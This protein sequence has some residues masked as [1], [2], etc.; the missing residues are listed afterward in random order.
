MESEVSFLER[1][2]AMNLVMLQVVG[3][4]RNHSTVHGEPPSRPLGGT[5]WDHEPTIVQVA[6]NQRNHSAVHGEPPSTLCMPW[7]HE[8]GDCRWPMVDCRN[9]NV[10]RSAS[11]EEAIRASASPR[12]GASALTLR[13][14]APALRTSPVHGERPSRPLGGTPWDH[15]P[16]SA[17]NAVTLDRGPVA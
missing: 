5:H 6:A 8:P 10:Q 1:I 2:G 16:T 3:N 13:P 15:E 17:R 4:Q 11:N 14:P 12:L 7:G 9:Q